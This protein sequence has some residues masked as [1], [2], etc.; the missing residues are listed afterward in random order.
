MEKIN[1]F[2]E[3]ESIEE[4]AN[5]LEVIDAIC[6]VYQFDKTQVLRIKAEKNSIRGSFN[7]KIVLVKL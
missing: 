2:L 4:L 6:T 5:V 1:E 3:S 7:E